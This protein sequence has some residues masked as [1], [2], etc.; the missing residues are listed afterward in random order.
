MCVGFFFHLLA[1]HGLQWPDINGPIA[2][3]GDYDPFSSSHASHDVIHSGDDGNFGETH[4]GVLEVLCLLQRLHGSE[5][6]L[7]SKALL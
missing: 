2:V 5:V 6:R 1:T 3:S 7:S 4:H